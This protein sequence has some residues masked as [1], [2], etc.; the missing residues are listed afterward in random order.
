MLQKFNTIKRPTTQLSLNHFHCLEGKKTPNLY[1]AMGYQST[2]A[3]TS[4]SCF[5]RD[6]EEGKQK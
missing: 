3:N 6:N 4:T 5:L 2:F 1:A